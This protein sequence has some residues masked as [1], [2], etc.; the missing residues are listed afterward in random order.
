MQLLAD[1]LDLAVRDDDL[2]FNKLMRIM[3]TRCMTQALY[4]GSAEVGPPEYYHYGLAAPIY[5]HFQVNPRPFYAG[6]PEYH[7][8]GLAAPIYTHFTSPIRRYADVV[9]HRLLAAVLHLDPLPET[10]R[11][12]EGLKSCSENLNKRHHNAQ[13]AGRGSTELHTLIFFKNQKRSWVVR[14]CQ[15]LF[16]DPRETHASGSGVTNDLNPTRVPAAPV[17][18]AIPHEQF[19]YSNTGWLITSGGPGFGQVSTGFMQQDQD[20]QHY[21]PAGQAC[22]TTVTPD[23]NQNLSYLH[24]VQGGEVKVHSSFA[25][26]RNL[27]QPPFSGGGVGAGLY[28]NL[29]VNNYGDLNHLWKAGQPEPVSEQHPDYPSSNA[30]SPP[31]PEVKEPLSSSPNVAAATVEAGATALS[32]ALMDE[33]GQH[34]WYKNNQQAMVHT[35]RLKRPRRGPVEAFGELVYSQNLSMPEQDLE[36]CLEDFL[37]MGNSSPPLSQ[38]Y[39]RG[40]PTLPREESDDPAAPQDLAS[41]LKAMSISGG[42]AVSFRMGSSVRSDDCLLIQLTSLMRTKSEDN[43]DGPAEDGE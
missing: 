30:S 4:F 28:V 20:T 26:D 36:E 29:V 3:S 16:Q 2:Y 5:T 11:D 15:M 21:A 31:Q 35:A 34:L 38:Q 18:A 10:S 40:T 1:S 14:I 32:T 22:I 17:T 12:R 41:G 39:F 33:Q 37:D 7:H 42:S 13:M 43:S 27:R 8:Y 25:A 19:H 9:V 6:P 24:K 23:R